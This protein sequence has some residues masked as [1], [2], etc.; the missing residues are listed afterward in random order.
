MANIKVGTF[1]VKGL[2]NNK[3]RRKIFQH[4]HQR[5]FDIICLQETHSEIKDE[6]L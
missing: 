3:K 1:N 6:A 2:H 5:Q 4:L